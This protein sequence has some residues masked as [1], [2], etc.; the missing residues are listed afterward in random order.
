MSGQPPGYVAL[1]EL[2]QQRR[3]AAQAG[4]AEVPIRPHAAIPR[5]SPRRG[6]PP[7]TPEERE[8]VSAYLGDFAR[9]LG[10]EAPLSST[11]T[12]AI[13]IFHAAGAPRE[14]WPDLLYQ[15]RAITKEHSAQIT[16][17]PSDPRQ[18]VPA[19]VRMPYALAVLEDLVGLR[20]SPAT[21]S[22]RTEHTS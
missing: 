8:L 13:R 22:P 2:I 7:G 15:M 4:A 20:T 12:R 16:K 6:R 14:R 17:K 9:E 11:V 10:D 21:R 5:Q 19:K 18:R 3:R 1:R